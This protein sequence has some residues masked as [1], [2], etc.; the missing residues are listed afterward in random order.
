MKMNFS[1]VYL[2]WGSISEEARKRSGAEE[3][4]DLVG[5]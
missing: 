4:G 5:E 3:A 1:L 2:W